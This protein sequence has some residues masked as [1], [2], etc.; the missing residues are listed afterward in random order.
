MIMQP[1]P[2]LGSTADI[3]TGIMPGYCKLKT[4]VILT[5]FLIRGVPISGFFW[6]VGSSDTPIQDDPTLEDYNV[7]YIVDLFV[8]ETIQ[9]AEGY[10]TVWKQTG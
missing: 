7:D 8:N 2:S 10:L 1:S 6:E 4:I 5:K 9:Q 3:F